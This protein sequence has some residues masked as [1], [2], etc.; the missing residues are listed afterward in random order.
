MADKLGSVGTPSSGL[1]QSL[2][3]I[4]RPLIRLLIRQ[5]I[6]FP[7][8]SQLLKSVY[9]EVAAE[10]A[11]LE[12]KRM[13]DSRLSLLTGVHRKDVRRLRQENETISMPEIKPTSLGAQVVACW[14]SD[15]DYVDRRGKARPL[16]RLSAQGEPSFERLVEEV[17]RQDVRARSLLDEWL[18]EG[19][20][21]I[22]DD[23][24]VHLKQEAFIPSD[25]FEQKAFFFGH[26][27]HDHLSASVEN[28]LSE[29]PV[30]FDRGVY[31]NN[32]KQKSVDELE[33]FVDEQA[34][35]LFKQLNKK[36]RAMQRRDSGK[37]GAHQRFRFGSYFYTD[38]TS[39]KIERGVDNED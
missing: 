12:G 6:T 7:F 15:E 20:V 38:D 4:L 5:Q 25:D 2:V 11:Y 32:L 35:E 10:E 22:D 30:Y 36:A 26:N 13:T 28:L 21:V 24:L 8:I 1:V 33:A 9:L 31:C 34:M 39:T 37:E 27:I 17:S 3:R 18:K 23:G 16:Y 19:V 14:I 29:K